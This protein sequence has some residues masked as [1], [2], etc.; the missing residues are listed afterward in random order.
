MQA[1]LHL[2]CENEGDWKIVNPLKKHFFGAEGKD[3]SAEFF[4]LEK[5]QE[6]RV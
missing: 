1:H 6:A 2:Y 3:A 5:F 4:L